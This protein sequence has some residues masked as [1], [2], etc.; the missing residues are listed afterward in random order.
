MLTLFQPPHAVLVEVHP[1]LLLKPEV[2]GFLQAGLAR[3]L[4]LPR[5]YFAAESVALPGSV[6]A[7][8]HR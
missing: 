5:A 2:Y 1:S 6:G 3:R 8:A 7:V 4:G